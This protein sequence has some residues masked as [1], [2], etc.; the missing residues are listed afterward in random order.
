MVFTYLRKIKTKSENPNYYF[1]IYSYLCL[2]NRHKSLRMYLNRIILS[3]FKN[4][5][6]AEVRFSPKLNCITGEN[7]A[8][9]T[10]LLEAIH[11]LSMTKSF[12][13]LQDRYICRYGESE[14]ALHGE[15]TKGGVPEKVAI[16]V[17]PDGDKVLRRNDKMMPRLSDHIGFLPIVA[18]SPTDTSLIQDSGEERRRL[19]NLIL[20]QTDPAYL[21]A[22]K[23]YNRTLQQRNK[24]LKEDRL[25]EGL[26]DAFTQ[27]LVQY[28]EP[29]ARRRAE[30]AESLNRWTADY[31]HQLSGG[32][33]TVSIAYESDA[34]RGSLADVFRETLQRDRVLRYTSAGVQREDFVFSLNGHPLRKSGSQGQQK[35]FLTALKLAQFAMMREQYGFSP[36][37]LLDDV[38]DKLDMSRVEFL[39]ELVS[40]EDFGQIFITDSNKV[41]LEKVVNAV[42]Q[43]SRFLQVSNGEV[44]G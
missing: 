26:L 14:C 15:Y 37:L 25:D 5:A 6:Q 9:K 17:R 12:L 13:P 1:A 2:H 20:S 24:M 34:L 29:V 7:G 21:R 40:R 38:F 31:Y 39:V 43:E 16:S 36:I 8:G 44:I 32:K 18:V 11:Y 35:T 41:R 23:L 10:N 19:M 30:L 27:M 28:G 42:T 33:E 4:L 3:N 22:I